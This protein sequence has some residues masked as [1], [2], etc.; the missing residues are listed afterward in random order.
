[1]MIVPHESAYPGFGS[2]VVLEGQDHIT[3]CKLSDREGLG[4]ATIK[5]VISKVLE[6]EGKETRTA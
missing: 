5:E 3:V 6:R 4:Y 1:M 2:K